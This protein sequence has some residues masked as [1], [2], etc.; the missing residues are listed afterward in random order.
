MNQTMTQNKIDLSVIEN[1]NV[2]EI[3][4]VANEFCLFIEEHERFDKSYIFPY[5]QR[6]LPLLYLKGSLLPQVEPNHE[7][8]NERYVI[9]ETWEYIFNS[10]RKLLADDNPYHFT[11]PDSAE[12]TKT[13][14]S[15][16]LADL[17]QDLKDFVILFAKPSY[18]AKI[19]AVYMCYHLFAQRWGKIIP[20]LLH[21]IH[22][23]IYKNQLLENENS[24]I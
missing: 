9:E 8:D 5:L 2:L 17:Y 18:Y 23:V 22:Y 15:E 16:N 7:T 20:L 4:T 11:E 24:H 19:N 3:L 13:S 14:I 21:Q 6:V 1:K 10:F 12:N